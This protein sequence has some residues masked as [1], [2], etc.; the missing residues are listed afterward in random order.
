MHAL[1][2]VLPEMAEKD[3]ADISSNLHNVHPPGRSHPS[4]LWTEILMCG[5]PCLF[6][7]SIQPPPG[8][9]GSGPK[10]HVLAGQLAWH[11]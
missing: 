9:V 6:A 5:A 10:L 8:I 7:V 11:L 3:A 1:G 4:W 2:A